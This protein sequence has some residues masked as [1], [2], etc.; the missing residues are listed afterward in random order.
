MINALIYVLR[1]S[2]MSKN[3]SLS[4]P[5]ANRLDGERD[6]SY[7]NILGC[8]KQ[9]NNILIF[10]EYYPEGEIVRHRIDKTLIDREPDVPAQ[11]KGSDE[12]IL[13]NSNINPEYLGYSI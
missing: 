2:E 13:G 4:R 6:A 9:K 10:F 5:I 8:V 12:M 1:N 7:H 3:T 11:K